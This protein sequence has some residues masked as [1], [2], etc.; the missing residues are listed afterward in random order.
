MLSYQHGY[1]AGNLADVHKHGYLAWALAAMAAKPKPLSYLETHAGRGLYDLSSPEARRTGEAAGGIARTEGWF[2]PG[3]PYL[4][5]LA[6]TRRRHGPSA[7]PGSPLIAALLLRPGDTLRLAELHPAE[8]EA[9]GRALPRPARIERT[10]GLRAA[11]AW[12]PPMPRRGLLVVD[13]SWEVKSDYEAVPAMLERVARKWPV[14]V[15]VL[16]YPLLPDGRHAP[17]LDRLGSALPGA[18]RHEVRFAPVRP[19]HGMEGSGLFVVNPP[20]GSEGR[21][22][23]LGERFGALDQPSR[24]LTVSR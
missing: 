23:W 4:G 14:G 9:L 3:D 15:L 21:L 16:W 10:D 12:T 17:M 20:W 13:P 2:A 6:G 5:A 18:L 7:Y 1:H 22:A 24:P 11:L 8:H 19:G